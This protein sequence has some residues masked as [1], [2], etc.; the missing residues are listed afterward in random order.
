MLKKTLI[1]LLPY[2]NAND[3]PRPGATFPHAAT[4]VGPRPVAKYKKGLNGHGCICYAC[5]EFRSPIVVE[6]WE[7]VFLGANKF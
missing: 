1:L 3:I 4:I 7:S 5:E 6:G 2:F